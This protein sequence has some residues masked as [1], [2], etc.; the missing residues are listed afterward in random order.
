MPFYWEIGD[1]T[2]PLVS[3]SLTGSGGGTNYTATMAMSIASASK[4]LYSTYWVQRT[5]GVLSPTDIK[6]FNFKSGYTNF[7]S[8]AGSS[9]VGGC[10]DIRTNGLLDPATEDKFDYGRRAHPRRCPPSS[11]ARS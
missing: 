1:K 11:Q 7:D 3:G 9:T 4:W 6:F 10:V 8:C 2:A 5:N